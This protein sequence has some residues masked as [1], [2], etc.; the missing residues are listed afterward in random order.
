MTLQFNIEK[1]ETKCCE[2]PFSYQEY[3]GGPWECGKCYIFDDLSC[4]EYDFKTFKYIK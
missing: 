4:K 1:G 3:G 2:C